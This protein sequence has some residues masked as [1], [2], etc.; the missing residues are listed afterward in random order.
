MDPSKSSGPARRAA[1]RQHIN[2]CDDFERFPNDAIAQVAAI[3]DVLFSRPFR[4]QARVAPHLL[5]GLPVEQAVAIDD[6]VPQQEG[7]CQEQ[8]VVDGEVN[9]DVAVGCRSERVLG[10][11]GQP[12]EPSQNALYFLA[13]AQCLAYYRRETNLRT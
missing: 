7:L 6:A 1:L 5:R 9:D 8:V 2:S 11:E 12:F 3:V 4:N 13:F 10:Q